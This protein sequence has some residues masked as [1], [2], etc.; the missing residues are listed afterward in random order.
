MFF[1]LVSG[2]K[3][4]VS[5]T[6]GAVSHPLFSSSSS[7]STSSA[8]KNGWSRVNH[9]GNKNNQNHRLFGTATTGTPTTASEETLA[10][11]NKTSGTQILADAADFVKPDRDLHEYRYLKLENNLQVLLV[12][13]AGATTSSASSDEP[14]SKVE[15]AAVHVQAGH[16]DDTI[17]G[18]AHFHEHMLF[19]GTE[20]YPDE[21]DY[22]GFLSKFG[23]F[24]NAYTDMED[25]NYYF[26]ATSQLKSNNPDETSEALVGGLDRLAQF[27]I[28]PNFETSMV[29]RELQAIDSEYRNGKTSDAWRNYQFLKSMGNPK[30]PF[31]K[32][33]C[34][35]YETLTSQG[36][37]V[38]QLQT[39]WDKYYKSSNIRLAVVG[40]SSLDALQQ[41]VEESFGQLAYSNEPPRRAKVNPN[42]AVFP[43]EHAVYDPEHPAF[44]KNELGQIREIIPLLESRMLKVKFATPPFAD[45][46]LRQTKP[47]RVLSHLMGH[48]SPGSL[49]SL[50]NE[51]GLVTSLSSGAALDTSD[52]ALFSINLSLTPKGM[53][54]KDKVLDLI[55]QW[56]SLIRSSA[57]E[58]PDL[59]AKYHDELRQMSSNSFKFRENGDPS[60][61]CSSVAELM[62]DDQ[63]LPADIL[64]DGSLC[65]DYDPVIAKAFLER[66]RADNC[67]I[68][69][70]DSGLTKDETPEEWKVEPLYGA[71][72]R[73]NAIPQ[74]TLHGWDNPNYIDPRLY[75]P[76]L[77]EYIPTDFSLRC[78]DKDQ[79]SA[80]PAQLE[81]SRKEYPK[82]LQER[83][84]FR[85]WHKM[86]RY[87]RVP[88]TFISL[89]IVTP[90]AYQSPRSMTL[91]RIYQRVLNDDLNS[92]VYDASLAGCNYRVSC[93]PSGFRLSVSGYSEKLPSL[94]DTLTTRMFSLMEEMKEGKESH[95][96]LFDKF[97]KAKENLL[98]ETK[99]YRL[100]TPYEVAT[101]NSRLI[102]E[103]KAWYL[104]NYV[105]ELEGKY[106]EL[107]PLTME[108]C[109]DVAKGCMTGRIKA[110]AMCT[111][112]IDEKGAREVVDVIDHHFLN[113]ARPLHAA[114]APS[115]K[116][117]KLPTR[118][119][120]VAIFGPGVAEKTIPVKYQE[121]A[122]S[123]SEENNAVEV[124]LQAGCDVS[125]GYE[126][127]GIL[128]LVSHMAYNSAYGQLRTR[129]QLGYIVSAHTRK[130]T[131][132][133]W[134][135]TVVVQSSNAP[136]EVLEERIEAWLK[137]FRQELE[138]MTPESLAMEANGVASQLMEGHTKLSQEVGSAWGE[139]VATEACAE[140]M[141][142]PAFDRLDRLADE[143]KLLDG[144]EKTA[145]ATTVNGN[146]R[147][148]P[149][150]LKTRIL[151]F[152]DQFYVA[153]APERRAL[154]SRV[155]NHT[156]RA[157]YEA[158]LEEPGVL[159]TYSDMRYL[160]Q[161]L[162][163][164]SV[165]PY[166]RVSESNKSR[167]Q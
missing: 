134:G 87:W 37:P 79:E 32:F 30:H 1:L 95:P 52:F 99:N 57:L 63:V 119:E 21:D 108:E 163:S 151:E 74:E 157:E 152:V 127:V 82:L 83:S 111:G 123:G 141:T 114:E 80:T 85:M 86:D 27:F 90:G 15:A 98:R 109:A 112:N 162:S 26:S 121:V 2:G 69:V 132:G 18:L 145:D 73:V 93:V 77:N 25:T 148:T 126:G 58:Q 4:F 36:S 35:N 128:D 13:T 68:S 46:V 144:S 45:P 38:P 72:Y 133:A 137:T 3:S 59:L 118:Q 147:K 51:E 17:P 12:S 70:M 158:S 92:F 97:Q 103:E 24:A 28:S 140:G 78:D 164:W 6:F 143:L 120:A 54:A 43:R 89:S 9:H 105:D 165:A 61:F 44:G 104:D 31:S 40:G 96:A 135:L 84:N 131:G 115:F 113:P 41:T 7:K 167:G 125:L 150:I 124:T 102:I 48:E 138:D 39:F 49:H 160:K 155:Y 56:L 146:A 50:L 139:I 94:L 154:V 16:F 19:L 22:E 71:T 166:W 136:P 55:F 101:Y 110:D 11:N 130:T 20:K 10:T 81:E 67:M 88:K 156:L 60:D 153:E 64:V 23:G 149:E 116:S 14:T 129:E 161:F 122:F 75:L 47:Y 107:D 34:G 5:K 33:G 29:E 91:G 65:D 117:M 142:T 159:S 66:L 62:F 100:D 8:S 76:A 42:A 53:A 106:A